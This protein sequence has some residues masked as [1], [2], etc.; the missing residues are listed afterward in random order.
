MENVDE[1]EVMN[2]VGK[3]GF[4]EVM[5]TS[6]EHGDGVLELMQYIDGCIP[7][8]MKERLE[9]MKERRKENWRMIVNTLKEEIRN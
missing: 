1:V 2:E 6:G 3:L 8:D 9:R 5:Y 4:K 7:K